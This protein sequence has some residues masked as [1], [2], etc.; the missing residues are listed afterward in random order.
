MSGFPV[1]FFPGKMQGLPSTSVPAGEAGRDEES[2][3]RTPKRVEPLWCLNAYDGCWGVRS[4]LPVYHI[5]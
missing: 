3:S 1:S 5:L 2:L 4:K